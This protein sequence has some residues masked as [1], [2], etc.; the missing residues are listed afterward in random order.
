MAGFKNGW[1]GSELFPFPYPPD[2]DD[3]FTSQ[4]W[5]E[6]VMPREEFK[7]YTQEEKDNILEW[8]RRHQEYNS[9][10]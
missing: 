6:C 2:W 8:H 5:R 4:V 9:G 3:S 10:E 1:T 7:P